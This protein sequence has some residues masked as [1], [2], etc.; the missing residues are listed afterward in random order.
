M[1]SLLPS[2]LIAWGC[3]TAVLAALLIYRSLVAMKEDDQLF[4]DAAEWQLEREQQS[5][6]KQLGRLTPFIKGV[7]AISIALLAMI[8]GVWIYRSILDLVDSTQ[9]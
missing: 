6:L 3:V 7:A 1:I 8:T 4:L 9:P 2:L 5:I